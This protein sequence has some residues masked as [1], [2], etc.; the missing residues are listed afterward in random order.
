ML[1]EC[2]VLG[3]GTLLG[4][5]FKPFQGSKWRA[6][7]FPF[8]PAS[9]WTPLQIFNSNAEVLRPAPSCFLGGCHQYNKQQPLCGRYSEAEP[10]SITKHLETADSC[11]AA[12]TRHS[13]SF[14]SLFAAMLPLCDRRFLKCYTQCNLHRGGKL[15]P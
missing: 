9:R 8:D 15:F 12:P 2:P 6:R 4:P 14:Y 3:V 5:E 13:G 1:R 10:H 11:Q 7:L